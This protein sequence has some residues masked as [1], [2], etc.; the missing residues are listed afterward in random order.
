MWN[1]L[2]NTPISLFSI[3]RAPDGSAHCGGVGDMDFCGLVELE[4]QGQ[5]KTKTVDLMRA[6]LVTGTL[7]VE[8]A[9]LNLRPTS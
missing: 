4:I 8:I 5:S 9:F 3:I 7:V 2:Q 6:G 1:Y